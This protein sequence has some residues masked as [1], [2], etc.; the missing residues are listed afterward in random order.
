MEAFTVKQNIIV[1]PVGPEREPRKEFGRLELPSLSVSVLEKDMKGWMD[2]YTKS[3]V[4][5]SYEET[6]G[7]ISYQS[8]DSKELMRLD[9]DNVGITSID[10]EKY[11]AAKESMARIK[12]ALYVE[13]MK[14]DRGPGNA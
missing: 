5:G 12:V 10:I 2:W 3:V 14:L 13:G 4:N 7:F 9:L 1:N 6:T 8:P 11:E